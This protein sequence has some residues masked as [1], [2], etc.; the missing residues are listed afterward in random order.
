MRV[1]KFGGSSVATPDAIRKVTSIIR[2]ALEAGPITVVVSA[3][4][5]VTN[6]LLASANAA[7]GRD[8]AWQSGWEELRS[9]HRSAVAELGVGAMP[10]GESPESPGV[11]DRLERCFRDLH[12][13]LRGIYLLREHSPRVSDSLVTY[14]ERLSAMVVAAA[15]RRA[16][17]EAEDVDTR[18]LILT[19]ARFGR[20]QVDF[21]ATYPRLRER[22]GGPGPTAVVTGFTGS[23]AE[24]HTTTLGRGG[25]DYTAA[26]LGAALDAE[27][28]ELW[29]DVSGVMSADPRIVPEAFA[30]AEMSYAELMELSH[31]GA[32][33]VYP[34]S[35]HP[36]RSLGIPLWIKNTFAPEHPGTRVSERSVPSEAPI[37]GITSIR[38]VALA[39]L[40]GDGMVGVPG[41]AQRLFGALARERVSV[42]LI[43]QSS[44]E[45]SI[46]FAV[47]AGDAEATRRAVDEEFALER[48][49]G[50]VGDLV[51]EAEHTVVAAVGEQ[52][53]H[54]PGI[55]ARLFGV[56]GEN[57]VNVRAIAQG[58]SE[59]NIS[60]VVEAPQEARAVR[61]IHGAFFAP[62]RRYARVGLLGVGRVGSELL[63]QIRD[64]GPRLIESEG[65]ELRVVAVAS[66][67]R[68][69]LSA[70]GLESEELDPAALRD[71]LPEA[72]PLDTEILAEHLCR[73]GGGRPF[74]VD[75]TAADGLEP[76]YLEVLGRG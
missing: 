17:I 45:H 71:R 49:V 38:H 46:C 3:F 57:G 4:G 76:L 39:R 66:S 18:G 12:D 30:Q 25:S 53:A 52:M 19:D 59:L 47:A 50:M 8:P 65:I 44:S 48:R 5:G 15:L 10:S 60:I 11:A 64:A 14:G 24:G 61:V 72:E 9:R 63:A 37:R 62:H 22:F 2:S 16:G 56:L 34:P 1:L 23:T 36:A 54:R 33:V 20:A 31:F 35:I 43:S 28:V 21:D 7:A 42:I 51:V 69:L 6:G 67:R 29:T 41:I 13:L 73:A 68:M 75:C 27:A 32:K 55:A 26:L 58:S 74:L 40:E 70:E